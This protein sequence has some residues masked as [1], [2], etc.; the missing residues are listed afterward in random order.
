LLSDITEKTLMSL[1][2]GHNLFYI[3]RNPIT[4]I[5]YLVLDNFTKI[6]CDN[7][8]LTKPRGAIKFY[9]LRN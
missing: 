6:Y 4:E 8:K 5:S 3:Y 1:V 7:E 2:D 9:T